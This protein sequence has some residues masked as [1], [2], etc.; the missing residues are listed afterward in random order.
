[1]TSN[2][3]RERLHLGLTDGREQNYSVLSVFYLSLSAEAK[4]AS[5]R[6]K[7]GIDGKHERTPGTSSCFVLKAQ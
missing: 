5:R 4:G 3:A 7:S 1:M 6:V 2:P